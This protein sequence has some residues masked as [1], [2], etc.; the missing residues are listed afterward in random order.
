MNIY[1]EAIKAVTGY[2]HPH[3]FTC[4]VCDKMLEDD[5]YSVGDDGKL[6]CV[7]DYCSVF[8][9]KCAGCQ[10]TIHPHDDSGIILKIKV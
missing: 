10:E 5:L 7:Q 3:C 8:S 6:Y 4:S 1:H 9:S 2:Y